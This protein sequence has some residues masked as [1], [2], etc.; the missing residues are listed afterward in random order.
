VNGSGKH[1][2][3]SL[4]SDD[5]VN[6]LDPGK[7]PEENKLFLITLCAIL[8]VVDSHADLIRLSAASP[9]NDCR[10]GG[11]E[12][13]PAVISVFLGD[14]LTDI[15]EGIAYNMSR[16]VRQRIERDSVKVLP[17]VKMDNSDRNRTSP[18]AFT[19]NKFEFR[20][21][22]AGQSVSFCNAVLNTGLAQVFARFAE[23]LEKAEDIERECAD[24]IADTIKNHGR[25]IYNGN[26]YDKIW[27]EEARRRGLKIMPHALDAFDSM[28]SPENTGFFSAA[29]VLNETECRARYEV[30]LESFVKTVALEAEV[31]LEMARRQIIPACA[32]YLGEL[33]KNLAS[34]WDADVKADFI[35]ERLQTLSK[36][37][38]KA[39]ATCKRLESACRVE[40][41]DMRQ[42]AA[43]MQ[44]KV[45]P[46]M[47]GLRA[48]CDT[49]EGLMPLGMWP[50]PAYNDLLHRI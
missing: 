37:C 19:G 4:L 38:E 8:E 12:A 20:M 25:I 2:N 16:E 18:F 42:T 22:G 3:F 32:G 48:A 40:T 43:H 28:V 14:A 21:P 24:I 35:K 26:N 1:N 9:G 49:L 27:L 44:E 10:L 17:G 11:N 34:L 50:F 6:F 33:A 5:G 46:A 23:R 45:R 47:E 36:E 7:H 39:E 15:L 13:P 29:G 31:M 41:K 30:L